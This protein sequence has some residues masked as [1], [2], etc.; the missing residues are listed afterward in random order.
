MLHCKIF[1]IFLLRRLSGEIPNP[2]NSIL[3][4]HWRRDSI[5]LAVGTTHFPKQQEMVAG[6]DALGDD[7]QT[8]FAGHGED[9]LDQGLVAGLTGV[10]FLSAYSDRDMV[11]DA[12][13]EGGLGYMVKPVDV[14]QLVPAIEAA[15]A[16]SRDLQALGK[17]RDQ[18]EEAL[19]GGRDTSTAIG[20]LMERQGLRRQEAFN[21]LRVR[22]R[23]QRSRLET[24]A[25]DIVD[26]KELL[27][28]LRLQG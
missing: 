22:A 9:R 10:L 15:L 1:C 18:L 8:Q 16:R 5:A 7:L 23:A 20:I 14:P 24:L 21:L 4:R 26:A 17:T 3:G 6:F 11:E 2:F 12:I 28:G 25:H 19:Q 27:N 13:N